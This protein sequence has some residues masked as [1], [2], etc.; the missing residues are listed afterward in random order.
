MKTS[1][2][3]QMYEQITKHGQQLVRLFDL[4]RDTD[5]VKLCKQL[6]RVEVEATRYAVDLCNGDIDPT[7]EE[8]DIQ[9]DRI[10]AKVRKILGENSHKVPII[11]NRDPRGHALKIDDGWMRD[12]NAVLHRD[13]GGYGIIAPDF[14]EQ[15]NEWKRG[16]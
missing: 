1:K 11:V 8:Q 16:G 3:M 5:P 6:R 7:E 10:I 2:Q 14:S 4:P 13:M 15:Q 12:H 9:H